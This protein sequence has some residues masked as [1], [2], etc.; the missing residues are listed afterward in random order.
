MI[1]FWEWMEKKEYDEIGNTRGG[2]LYFDGE[3]IECIVGCEN[4][5]DRWEIPKQMLIGY[6]IECILECGFKPDELDFESL[7]KQAKYA[8]MSNEEQEK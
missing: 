3:Y 7:A 8:L 1:R 2:E 4:H 6:L 5:R